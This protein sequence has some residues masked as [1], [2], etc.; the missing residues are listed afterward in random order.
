[1]IRWREEGM[2]EM[3]GASIR[4]GRLFNQ[5]SGKTFIAAIDHGLVTGARAGSE[6]LVGAL[7]RLVSYQPEGI[8]LSAGALRRAGHLFAFHGAPTPIIRGDF[9]L[10]GERVQGLGEHYRILCSPQEAATLGAGALILFLAVGVEDGA[11][12]ADNAQEIARAAAEAHRIGIPLIIEVVPWGERLPGKRDGEVIRW[13]CRMAA[14]LGGDL[15]KTEYTGDR[16]SMTKVVQSCPV[17]VLILGGPRVESEEELLQITREAM[18]AGVRG[19]VYGRNIWQ[20]ED[21]QRISSSIR[22]IVH[23]SGNHGEPA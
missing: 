7:K 6:D 5:D 9:L 12:L 20:A 8:L 21:P 14:E 22:R 2:P 18:E 17:P 11:M 19:V 10:V 16:E 23:S 13:G 15:I 4:A 1:M 3:A